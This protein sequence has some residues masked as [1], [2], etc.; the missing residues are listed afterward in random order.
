VELRKR[1]CLLNELADRN[2]DNPKGKTI[3]VINKIAELS[4]LI[5]IDYIGIKMI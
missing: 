5:N 2:L 4:V 1:G 3:T